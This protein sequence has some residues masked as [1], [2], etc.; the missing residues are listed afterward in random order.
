MKAALD[1]LRLHCV[2]RTRT[3]TT[4]VARRTR[5][6]GAVAPDVARAVDEERRVPAERERE[7]ERPD[8]ARH[9]EKV[10]RE[11]RLGD[12]EPREERHLEE[13]AGCGVVW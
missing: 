4:S 12:E 6:V 13:A 5:V 9:A 10:V 1:A 11:Q 2:L 8:H 7:R 3:H